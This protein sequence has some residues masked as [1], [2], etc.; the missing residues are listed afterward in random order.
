MFEISRHLFCNLGG[1]HRICSAPFALYPSWI[2]FMFIHP[3]FSQVPFPFPNPSIYQF[4]T[5][6]L[7]IKKCCQTIKSKTIV[8][9][10]Y[11][12]SA[13]LF[14]AHFEL[15]QQIKLDL[16]MNCSDSKDES[17]TNWTSQLGF[18]LGFW[19]IQTYGG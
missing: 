18:K 15:T 11:S 9:F 5:V 7:L 14:S 16:R 13:H 1:C 4:M 17:F 19:R 3:A 12:V 8:H 2:V 6:T 10:K